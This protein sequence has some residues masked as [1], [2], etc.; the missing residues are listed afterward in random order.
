MRFA[1]LNVNGIK[2]EK[3]QSL[4]LDFIVKQRIDILCLQESD[5]VKI[6]NIETH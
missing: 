1:T 5:T 3:R 2:Q 4:V 6:R